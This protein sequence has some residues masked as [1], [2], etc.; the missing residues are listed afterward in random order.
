MGERL[1]RYGWPPGE[2]RGYPHSG[3]GCGEPLQTAGSHGQTC[4]RRQRHRCPAGGSS[5]STLAGSIPLGSTCSIVAIGAG[6]ESHRLRRFDPQNR[7]AAR[8]K[9]GHGLTTSVQFWCWAPGSDFIR[10]RVARHPRV[11]GS[12]MVYERPDA[13][14]VQVAVTVE[15]ESHRLRRHAWP[16]QF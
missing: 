12:K 4:R 5:P 9:L 3:E 7:Q 1:H 16:V 15:F 8:F 11:M 2:D 14:P 10:P 13:G 6:F